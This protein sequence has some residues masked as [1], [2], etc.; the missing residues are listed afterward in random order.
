MFGR[1][2][3]LAIELDWQTVQD[4]PRLSLLVASDQ[5]AVILKVDESIA[6]FDG[7]RLT[8]LI[9][10]RVSQ[11]LGSFDE[12]DTRASVSVGTGESQIRN[13]TSV[14]GRH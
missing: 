13:S 5:I 7:F 8:S 2:H 3:Y 11:Y 6:R 9:S 4:R 12:T 1:T 10:S 14:T